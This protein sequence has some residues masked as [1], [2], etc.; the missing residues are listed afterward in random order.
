M[1]PRFGSPSHHPAFESLYNLRVVAPTLS[2]I[3]SIMCKAMFECSRLRPNVLSQLARLTLRKHLK[4]SNEEEL[5]ERSQHS[6]QVKPV[7]K[8]FKEEVAFGYR[9]KCGG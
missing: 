1:V 6:A 7:C 5:V 4:G 2:M 8:D 3:T 9:V